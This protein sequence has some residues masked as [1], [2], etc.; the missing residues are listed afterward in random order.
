MMPLNTAER[1]S[2][3]FLFLLFFIISL[4]I[5][6]ATVFFGVQVPLKQNELLKSQIADFQNDREFL[7]KFSGKVSETWSMLDK[8]DKLDG[9]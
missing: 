9:R 1:K 4:V 2:A 5:V 8:I 6:V 3:F 7:Q